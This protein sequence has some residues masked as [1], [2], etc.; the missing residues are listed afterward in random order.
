MRSGG[1]HV[2]V[3]DDN[4]DERE[5][6][7]QYLRLAGFQ[8]TPAGDGA[9]ALRVFHE[10]KVDLVLVDLRMPVLDGFQTIEAMRAGTKVDGAPIIVL[11]SFDRPNLKV[12][13]LELGADDYVVKPVNLAELLARAKAALR[14][15]ARFRKIAGAL[16]G[17]F[18]EIAPS[19]LIQTMALGERTAQIDAEIGGSIIMSRGM[20]ADARWRSLAGE[21]A[22]ERICLLNTG[23]FKTYFDRPVAL[24]DAPKPAAAV[25]L[26]VF[27]KLDEI[28]ASIAEIGGADTRLALVHDGASIALHLRDP[29]FTPRSWLLDYPGNMNEGV[30]LLLAAW[31]DGELMSEGFKNPALKLSSTTPS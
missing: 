17:D 1:F 7:I 25:L 30:D 20:F 2:L 3:A 27:T 23:R 19:V 12:K 14:R 31:R 11:S 6:V 22:L 8:V 9:E 15:S 24:R 18:A 13:A 26:N 5:P 16:E 21:Q 10:S 4:P 29:H 28:F